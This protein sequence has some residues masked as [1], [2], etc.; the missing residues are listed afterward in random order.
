[1]KTKYNK[2]R[3]TAFVYEALIREGT[4]A[5]L[6]GDHDRKNT[7]VKLI[8]K[9]FAPDSILYK[10]LQCYQSLYGSQGLDKEV[11]EKIMKE[12]KLGH[13]VLDPHGLFVSQTDLIKDVNKELEPAVFNNFVPN[14]KS[15]ANIHKMFN[16]MSSPKESV[17]LEQAVLKQMSDSADST[18]DFDVDNLVVEEFVKKFNSKYDSV[19]LEEQKQLLSL[20]ISSFVDNALEFKMFLNEELTRLKT[21]LVNSKNNEHVS[22]DDEMIS[23]TNTIIEKLETLSKGEA[24]TNMLLTVLKVQELVKE[25]N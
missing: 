9:H 18:N 22:T 1:M 13:R 12:A 8:K 4:S 24:D 16:S 21:E 20:Y 23:K 17:I 7:V 15:L 6:Q 14:Y 3:N 5:I 2:K 11:C 10:D 25:F 19:L